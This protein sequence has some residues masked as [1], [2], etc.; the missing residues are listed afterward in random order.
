[1]IQ[2]T[3][4]QLHMMASTAASVSNCARTFSE[5]R[6][7]SPLSAAIARATMMKCSPL[8]PQQTRAGKQG[9]RARV[10]GN[11]DVLQIGPRA[12]DEPQADERDQVSV[13]IG[14]TAE[15]LPRERERAD[16]RI[17]ERPDYRGDGENRGHA[18]P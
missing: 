4:T 10:A 8:Q 3:R 18:T 6:L 2:N 13:G 14:E 1:M 16:C 15:V 9:C 5:S 7:I 12:N 11:D 17:V